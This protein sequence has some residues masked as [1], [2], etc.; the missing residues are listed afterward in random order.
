MTVTSTRI[1]VADESEPRRCARCPRPAR[2]TSS[3]DGG[4]WMTYCAGPTC[5]NHERICARCQRLFSRSDVGAGIKYCSLDCQLVVKRLERPRDRCAWC[6]VPRPDHKVTQGSWPYVCDS[7]VRPIK[8]V[9]HQLK[10]HHLTHEYGQRLR[11]SPRCEICNCDV[12]TPSRR[13]NDGKLRPQLVI[14]HDHRCCTRGYRSC[15]RCFRGFI[16]H[17]CNTAIG[18]LSDDP[19]I[20][21]SAAYYLDRTTAPLT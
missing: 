19:L 16:C 20:A 4:Y 6:D 1:E 9:I 7:C 12:L 17:A 18:M 11:D 14:D 13:G 3:E 8:N 21:L 10:N 15:G 5:S 2:W